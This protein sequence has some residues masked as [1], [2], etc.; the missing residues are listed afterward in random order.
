MTSNQAKIEQCKADIKKL[1]EE[2]KKLEKPENRIGYDEN[3]VGF[4]VTKE[5]AEC[6]SRNVGN[7]VYLEQEGWDGPFGLSWDYVDSCRK[8]ERMT[9]IL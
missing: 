7:I 6:V 9:K 4:L 2:L 8:F 3:S 1:Q 5:I